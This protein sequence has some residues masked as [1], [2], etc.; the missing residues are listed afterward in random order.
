MFIGAFDDLDQGILNDAVEN[1]P[2]ISELY[3]SSRLLVGF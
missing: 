3:T 1:A 2:T